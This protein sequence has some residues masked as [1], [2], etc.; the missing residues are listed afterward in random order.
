M[1]ISAGPDIIQ[2]GLV[3][4]LDASDRNSYVSGSTTWFDLS[5]NGFN[6]NLF[7]SPTFSSTNAGNIIFDGVNDYCDISFSYNVYNGG[8]TKPFSMEIWAKHDLVTLVSGELFAG[9][10]GSGRFM[11][12]ILG[13]TYTSGTTKIR[14][15]AMYGAV[16]GSEHTVYLDQDQ[17]WHQF[18]MTINSSSLSSIYVDGVLAGTRSVG[19]ATTAFFTDIRLA[20]DRGG[21]FMPITFG[22]IK[23]YNRE[24]AATEILNN[25]SVNKVRFN[26]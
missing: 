2:D 20:R 24:L 11:G 22:S 25:Y 1:G 13:Y 12:V 5:G 26:R 17:K 4:A 19:V 16:G 9:A 7:N 18:V 14:I 15:N 8:V 6:G 21:P 3:L 23:A 10:Y